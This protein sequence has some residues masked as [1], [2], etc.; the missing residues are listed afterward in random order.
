M[1]L[2]PIKSV[3]IRS[4]KKYPKVPGSLDLK[5]ELV[6][7]DKDRACIVK[8][9]STGGTNYDLPPTTFGRRQWGEKSDD[10]VIQ[11]Y[12]NQ[13]PDW[14]IIED[15]F[16]TKPPYKRKF[17]EEQYLL[18]SGAKVK[19]TWSPTGGEKWSDESGFE[20]ETLT[21]EEKS[22]IKKKVE[23]TAP[24]GLDQ[25]MTFENEIK[26][27]KDST[28]F[29]F[30]GTMTD[31]EILSKV[32]TDWR[33]KVPGYDKLSAYNPTLIK[34]TDWQKSK[35]TFEKFTTILTD[36][37]D[38]LDSSIIGFGYKSPL[39]TPTLDTESTQTGATASPKIKI[40]IDLP[41]GEV[42]KAK[43][44]ISSIIITVGSASSSVEG[45][46]EE[47][48]ESAYAGEEETNLNSVDDAP[49]GDIYSN[50]ETES[51][52]LTSTTTTNSTNTP[53]GPG[54][55]PGSKLLKKSGS[56]YFIVGGNGLAG[57][58]LKLVIKDLENYLNA[59]GFSGT[60]LGNN[61]II[62]DLVASTYPNSPAR[63]VAS[64][65]GAGL[66][67]DLTFNIPGK[68]WTGIGDN[69]NLSADANLTRLISKWVTSQGDLTW[70]AEWGGSSPKDGVVKG[71][72]ITEYH[73]FEIKANKIQ[74]YWKPFQ[75][76][77]SKMGFDIAKLNRTG[78][79]S[80]LYRLSQ[81]LLSSAGVNA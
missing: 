58:R 7:N 81:S 59:N 3:R 32:I 19:I 50:L 47:F 30:E 67:I 28:G 73:H 57:H 70:G 22:T 52:S 40:T 77:L 14:K 10:E 6:Q 43:E 71:R 49:V 37:L 24:D 51:P 45:L 74:D 61:G 44:D 69:A 31:L 76:E 1:A 75:S 64:L 80:D 56:L 35:P 21:G 9:A 26:Y 41:K 78:K 29:E 38:Y 13:I 20:L 36:N 34:L 72:G 25:N 33:I 12:L 42:I 54:P 68:K 4:D 18:N 55:S 48:T 16:T 23:I 17:G 5:L 8:Y 63:A 66:A 15:P 39:K 65:H 79:S 46:D 11:S 2:I 53:V 27:S 60:K 62:R